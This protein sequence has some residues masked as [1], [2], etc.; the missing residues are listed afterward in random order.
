M[1]P[2]MRLELA[3]ARCCGR[4]AF[5]RPSTPSLGGRWRARALRP[6]LKRDPLGSRP[7]TE[8]QDHARLAIRG[9]RRSRSGGAGEDQSGALWALLAVARPVCE[10]TG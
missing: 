1:R 5:V 6:Q 3:G 4:I 2:N 10:L 9:V 7:N 8:K